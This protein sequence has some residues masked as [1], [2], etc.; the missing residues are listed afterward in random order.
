MMYTQERAVIPRRPAATSKRSRRSVRVRRWGP[1]REAVLIVLLLSLITP[2]G[3][4]IA[5]ESTAVLEL[6]GSVIHLQNI[7]RRDIP[8]VPE[9]AALRIYDLDILILARDGIT[10]G[11]LAHLQNPWNLEP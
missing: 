6:D 2:G 1:A 3:R 7:G 8:G 11:C 10:N 4:G 9:K 5:G